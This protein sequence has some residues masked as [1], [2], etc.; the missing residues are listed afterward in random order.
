MTQTVSRI[1]SRIMRR[2][3]VMTRA[4]RVGLGSMVFGVAILLMVV[5]GGCDAGTIG[6]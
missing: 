5:A 2:C 4:C 1:M 3:G 6:M